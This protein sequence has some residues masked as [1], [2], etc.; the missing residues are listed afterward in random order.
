MKKEVVQELC[1]QGGRAGL[2]VVASQADWLIAGV[3]NTCFCGHCYCLCDS[4]TRQRLKQQTEKS[5]CHR[6]IYCSGGTLSE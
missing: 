4:T 6:N 2:S 3:L 5:R 1:E